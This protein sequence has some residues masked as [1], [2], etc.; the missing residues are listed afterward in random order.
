MRYFSILLIALSIQFFADYCLSQDSRGSSTVTGVSRTFNPAI[1][2]N[3]LFLGALT[4]HAFEDEGDTLLMIEDEHEE[5]KAGFDVEEVELQLTSF[6]DPFLKADLILAMEGTEGIELEEGFVTTLGLPA[7]L[8]VRGGKF[9][10]AVG[11][12]NLLHSH[13]FPFVDNNLSN[14]KIFGEEGLNEVG[15]EG[16]ILLPFSWYSDAVLQVVDGDN[17]NI[18]NSPDA[19]DLVYIGHLKNLW[20]LTE[21]TTLEI[22]GSGAFGK[23]EREEWSQVAGAD[24]TVKWRPLRRTKYRGAVFQGEVLH[25]SVKDSLGGDEESL[26]FS[27]LTKFQFSRRWWIQ[28]RFDTFNPNGDVDEPRRVS[29]LLAFVPTE[30]S[31][32]RFQYNL[33]D[34]GNETEHEGKVQ[35]NFTIGS[36]PAH[37]Y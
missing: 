25:H 24:F 28:G 13:Q 34:V 33:I 10:G 11:K 7:N 8:T 18:Y 5:L 1:S 20:D 27:F 32:L 9:F 16:S 3:G 29:G 35:L 15:V 17:E 12:Q 31:A 26:G 23:D 37:R 6:V 2:V 14:E 21:S 4:S 19:K 30:F 36:H 22:G